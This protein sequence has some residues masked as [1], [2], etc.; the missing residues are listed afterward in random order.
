MFHLPEVM[1]LQQLLNKDITAE[2]LDLL[3]DPG[4]GKEVAV[5]LDQWA[6]EALDQLAGQ[7]ARG[8]PLQ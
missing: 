3:L 7:V 6:A 5:G 2:P 4:M 8:S 1:V